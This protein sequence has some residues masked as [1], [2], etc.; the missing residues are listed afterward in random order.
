MSNNKQRFFSVGTLAKSRIEFE[1]EVRT[2]K[3]KRPYV[4]FPE[5]TLI[6]VIDSYCSKTASYSY[7][8]FIIPGTDA[9]VY[10]IMYYD[11]EGIRNINWA[12][13]KLWEP[14]IENYDTE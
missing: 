11:F 6:F 4:Y 3:K 7:I 2:G 14:E 5:K 13:K 10:Q 8:K 12:F 9:T 1:A